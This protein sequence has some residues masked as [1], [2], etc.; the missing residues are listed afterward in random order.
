MRHPTHI[1]LT[2]TNSNAQYDSPAEVSHV[3]TNSEGEA[4]S[5]H[6]L[7]K[8]GQRKSNEITHINKNPDRYTLIY[9]T[10]DIKVLQEAR[11]LLAYKKTLKPKWIK[12]DSVK[13]DLPE[14]TKIFIR[15]KS[16][17]SHKRANLVDDWGW[18]GGCS[19]SITHY[20]IEEESK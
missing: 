17:N 1:L 20:K 4:V 19:S 18:V 9:A 10:P 16:G 13:P 7:N 15:T 6:W 11:D 14:G 12:C 5:Y 3:G 8:H 2:Y